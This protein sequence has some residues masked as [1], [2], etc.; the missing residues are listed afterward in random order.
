MYNNFI[1]FNF[2]FA[3]NISRNLRQYLDVSKIIEK[4][5]GILTDLTLY[6]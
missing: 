1:K 3:N 6:V 4:R 5:E 2:V